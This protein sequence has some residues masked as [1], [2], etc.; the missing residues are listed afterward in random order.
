[1][2]QPSLRSLVALLGSMLVALSANGCGGGSGLVPVTGTVTLDGKPVANAAVLFKPSAGQPA[3]GTTDGDGKFSLETIKPGDGA[4]PGEHDV[5]V[6]GVKMS[7]VQQT[8][9]GLSDADS[10]KVKYEWFVPQKY[11][12]PETSGLKVDVKRGMAPVT[13]ELKSK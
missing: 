13:L 11:S 7:G 3:N 1:M 8:A 4:M 9:D 12:I 5:T 10:S 6:T 2:F